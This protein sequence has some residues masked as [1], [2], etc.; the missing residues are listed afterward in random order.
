MKFKLFLFLAILSSISLFTFSQTNL[1]FP[2]IAVGG[3]YTTNFIITNTGDTDADVT[4][5]FFQSGF[6]PWSVKIENTSLTSL[7]FTVESKSMIFFQATSDSTNIDVGFAILTSENDYING[8]ATYLLEDESGNLI[9]EVSV[10]AMG[11][12]T[13]YTLPLLHSTEDQ[14]NTA[15][16]IVNISDLE[17]SLS[18]SCYDEDGYVLNSL[19]TPIDLMSGE[20]FP[21]YITDDSLFPDL[22]DSEGAITLHLKNVEGTPLPFTCMGLIQDGDKFAGFMPSKYCHDTSN[23]KATYTYYFPQIADGGGYTTSIVII[24]TSKEVLN[25]TIDFF[26]ESGNPWQLDLEDFGSF[27]SISE[28]LGPGESEYLSTSNTSPNIKAGYAT[29]T[30]N[31]PNVLLTGAYEY[32]D[33]EDNLLSVVS[34]PASPANKTFYLPIIYM[35]DKNLKSALSILNTSDMTIDVSLSFS[36]SSSGLYYSNIIQLSP[37]EKYVRYVSDI[38]NLQNDVRELLTVACSTEG[39]NISV[40][41]LIDDRG[42]LSNFPVEVE[43]IRNINDFNEIEPNN[44]LQQAM[45]VVPPAKVNGS[46]SANEDGDISVEVGSYTDDI[47]DIYK[48]NTDGGIFNIYLRSSSSS[49]DLDL[50]IYDGNDVIAYSNTPD[51]SNEE[52]KNLYLSP[53]TYYVFVSAYDTNPPSNQQVDYFIILSAQ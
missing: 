36:I 11:V 30:V 29:I 16:S 3:G 44:N 34:I 9:T 31:N 26:D 10:P 39:A 48:F 40:M 18:I 22:T 35:P 53:G 41:G 23:K 52:I 32:T 46:T 1:Y 38:F 42:M 5:N 14:L 45:E 13:E 37:H 47:E 27:T 51:Y 28:E 25:F 4:I 7:S 49:V 8:T 15:I 2:Q 17:G 43:Q 50:Y 21:R 12:S 33:E 20:H 24:N 6:A 19:S